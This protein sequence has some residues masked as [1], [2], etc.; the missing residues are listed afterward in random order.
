MSSAMPSTA[1]LT[2]QAG[3]WLV[4]LARATIAEALGRPLP[5]DELHALE[6]EL[7]QPVY[8]SK[9]GVFVTLTLKGSLR[10]CIGTLTSQEA[11]VQNVRENAL[12]AAFRDPRFSPLTMDEFKRTAVEV[13]V[14]SPPEPLAYAD[15]EDLL[16]RIRPG[17]D[18][19]IL[20][21]GA[22]SATFLPQVWK[23]L[24]RREDFL[25]HLCLKAGL[26]AQAWRTED[27]SVET[28]QVQ[29]FEEKH[30]R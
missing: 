17:V 12:N 15:P 25:S 23:Q 21:K 29:Y 9:G 24:P 11:L 19:L 1:N 18:G 26:P 5:A 27:L 20:R 3:Q 8:H 14:L 28:Y 6:D 13:S 30:D 4:R 16:A 2:A 10:G 22:A 7:Q